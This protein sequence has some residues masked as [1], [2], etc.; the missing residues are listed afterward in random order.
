MSGGAFDEA[1]LQRSMPALTPAAANVG[2]PHIEDY[3]EFYKLDGFVVQFDCEHAFGYFS[4]GGYRIVG[5]V[6]K[7]PGA[8]ASVVINHGYF[9][10]AGLYAHLIGYFLSRGIAVFIYDLPGHGLSEGERASIESFRHYD[11]VL[12][13]A[14]D[15]IEP[16]GL[17]RPL[18][19]AGQSTGAA[20]MMT[21][22]LQGNAIGIDQA[23]LL[24]PLVR[25][26]A[27]NT[28]RIWG[29]LSRYFA[30]SL[31]RVFTPNSGDKVFLR[32]LRE[33]DPMQFHRLPLTWVGAMARWHRR[34]M[35]LPATDFAPLVVQGEK[36]FTVNW[37]FNLPV[38]EDKFRGVTI[39]RLKEASHH[40]VNETEAVRA[41]I[42]RALDDYLGVRVHGD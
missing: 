7:P 10:H 9:D 18:I 23:V 29:G 6:L 32:F 1:A 30:P 24:A 35:E 5:H 4:A 20:I 37:R 25:P 42:W 8:I 12:R 27:W 13:D 31:R 15:C 40:L 38:I 2:N 39:H 28:A 26:T 21:H 33:E 16:F 3:L 19:G 11:A 22:L 17:P 36:D 14:L 41:R 34:F